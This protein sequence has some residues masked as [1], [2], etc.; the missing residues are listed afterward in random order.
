MK[1]DQMKDLN[2]YLNAPNSIHGGYKSS[3]W[4]DDDR[5]TILLIKCAVLGVCFLIIYQWIV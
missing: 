1:R 4:D 3:T 2:P 5:R